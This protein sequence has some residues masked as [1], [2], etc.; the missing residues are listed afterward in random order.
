MSKI[1]KKS[2]QACIDNGMRLLDDAQWLEFQKP[3]LT[4]YALTII[5]QEEFAKAFLLYLVKAKVIPWSPRIWQ[6][7]RDHKCKQLICLVLDYMCPD[8]DVFIQRYSSEN[9][10]KEFDYPDKVVDAIHILRYEKI[11]RWESS[12]W[13]WAEDPKWDSDAQSV[14]TGSRDRLKQSSLYVDLKKDGSVSNYDRDKIC[15]D[16]TVEYELARRIERFMERLME[17][18]TPNSIEYKNVINTFR[19]LF[20]ESEPLRQNN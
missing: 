18:E 5:A 16:V 2:I 6:A 12:T 17:K 20:T 11:G 1:T 7:A 10:G 4:V 14:A 13:F 9:V 19:L 8:T 15:Q 3:P